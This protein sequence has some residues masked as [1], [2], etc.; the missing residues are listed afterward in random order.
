M[1]DQLEMKQLINATQ[2]YKLN[3]SSVLMS[4]HPKLRSSV[5]GRLVSQNDVVGVTMLAQESME[6]WSGRL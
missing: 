5:L 3:I 4:V 1:H 6:V 2:R